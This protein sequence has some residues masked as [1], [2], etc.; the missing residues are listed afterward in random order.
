MFILNIIL[1]KRT[2]CLKFFKSNDEKWKKTLNRTWKK[3]S[4]TFWKKIRDNWHR[5]TDQWKPNHTVKVQKIFSICSLYST[6]ITF[7]PFIFSPLPLLVF[8][9]PPVLSSKVYPKKIQ[10]NIS[11]CLPRMILWIFCKYITKLANSF[12]MKGGK[13]KK[14]KCSG[15]KMCGI[16]EMGRKKQDE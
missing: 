9:P 8:S 14:N 10:E 1:Q 11:A 4:T 2:Q 15:L 6:N 13:L 16:Q 12:L 5:S 3:V 7:H